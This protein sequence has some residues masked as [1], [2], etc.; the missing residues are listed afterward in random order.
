[1]DTGVD[2]FQGKE[3]ESWSVEVPTSE[4]YCRSAFLLGTIY[5]KCTKNR[6]DAELV[7][8]Q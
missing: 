5:T 2:M 7:N 1:M 6:K 4:K 8:Y 3:T